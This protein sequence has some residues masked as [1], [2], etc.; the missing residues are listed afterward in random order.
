MFSLI[1]CIYLFNRNNFWASLQNQLL[2][3]EI[4]SWARFS[5]YIF[6]FTVQE[7]GK[8]LY[9]NETPF[10]FCTNSFLIVFSYSGTCFVVS[11][12]T[13]LQSWNW[14]WMIFSSCFVRQ[15]SKLFE[16]NRRKP[17]NF[18]SL[19]RKDCDFKLDR[20]SLLYAARS[21][22]YLNC[23]CMQILANLHFKCS[24]THSF[25]CKL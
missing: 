24:L 11:S 9:E 21:T 2:F 14:N 16:R 15:L 17:Q 4:L 5:D 20:H 13:K 22:F 1:I 3:Y 12:E 19:S 25:L 18:L 7:V 8:Q 23:V 6:Y 10:L